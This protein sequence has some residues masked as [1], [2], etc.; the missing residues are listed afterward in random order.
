LFQI[1]DDLAEQC[2]PL[3]FLLGRWIGNGIGG[4]PTIDSFQFAQEVE[5]SHDGRP[6]LAYS[7]QSWL[8]DEDG[9]RIRALASETGYWRPQPE[10]GLEVVLTHPMGYAEVW[11][12]QVGE[13]KVELSTDLV[14][15][16]STAKDYSA[17][18]RIY[19]LV[20]SDLLW[21]FDMAAMGQPL[22]SHL[23]AR[24]RRVDPL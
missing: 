1:P 22:Q 8:L 6:F 21:A 20:E 19:G 9:Q 13:A 10:G 24:L 15:R 14:A 16:T 2:Y 7:S 11:V 12:G 5:F 17:G 23:S 18:T 3:A 4:Y